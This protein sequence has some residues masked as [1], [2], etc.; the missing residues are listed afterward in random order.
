MPFSFHANTLAFGGQ[1][2]EAGSKRKLLPS[3]ASVTLPQAGGF[4]E[5]TVSDYCE[6][7]IS[8]VR[9]ESRV[10]GNA[11]DER[12]FKTYAN[13]TIYGLDIAGILQADVLS[14]TIISINRRL[15]ERPSESQISLEANIVG[16]VIDGVPYDV[17]IDTAPFRE[18]G[19]L[20]EFVNSFTRMSGEEVQSA[21]AAYNWAF[22][23]CQTETAEGTKY[24]APAAGSNGVRATLVRD[25]TPAFPG[26]ET[27]LSRNG[28]TLN[29]PKLGLVHIGEVLLTTGRRTI[30]MIRIEPEL[31]LRNMLSE[32]AQA[33]P[34]VTGTH[35]L[36]LAGL[37]AAP[38]SLTD[39]GSYT[40]TVGNLTGNGTDFG[41]P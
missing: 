27:N 35:V 17:K 26:Q 6:E 14:A 23:D 11:F 19:T 32:P 13:V 9:A 12:L 41:R 16:L 34:A 24:H 33:E 22:Q 1:F 31:T 21:A 37:G 2:E 28:F 40:A 36:A 3:Q 5:S 30:N 29:V 18:N 7:G 8:F 20:G 38:A 25:I 39:S 15:S 4:G 10:Y